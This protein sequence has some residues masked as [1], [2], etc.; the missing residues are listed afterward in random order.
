[1]MINLN[2]IRKSPFRLMTWSSLL[3]MYC[4]M[5]ICFSAFTFKPLDWLELAWIFRVHI[6]FCQVLLLVWWKLEILLKDSL[7]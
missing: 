2:L 1:M 6:F 4:T 7:T 5:S 3:C